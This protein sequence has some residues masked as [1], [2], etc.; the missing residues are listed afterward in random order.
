MIRLND[1]FIPP[2][3]KRRPTAEV[4][5]LVQWLQRGTLEQKHDALVKLVATG[6]EAALTRCLAAQNPATA[7]LAT[8][9]LWECWL[10]EQGPEAR[11]KIDEGIALMEAGDLDGASK[12]FTFLAMKYPAW[13][14]ARNKQATVLYLKGLA[15]DSLDLCRLVVEMKPNHFAAWNGLALC[16]V[17]LEAW[18]IA[19]EAA[20]KALRLQPTA[21]ANQ[22]IIKLAE[23]RLG[24]A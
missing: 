10:N 4:E 23:A 1:E 14:E 17:Q 19:L 22:E 18:E 21:V 3:P 7:Q 15:G 16:A 8:V 11:R 6:E 9:G 2:D 20:K 5:D 13:A 24:L 12:I